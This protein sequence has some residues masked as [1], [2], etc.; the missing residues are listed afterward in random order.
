MKLRG[1]IFGGGLRATKVEEEDLEG[2]SE[3]QALSTGV[4]LGMP[5]VAGMRQ[6]NSSIGTTTTLPS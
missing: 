6:R 2:G 4:K 1:G 3:D 5:G